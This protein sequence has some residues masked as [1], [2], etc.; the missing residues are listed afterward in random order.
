MY[1]GLCLAGP[2][3]G[4]TR[5]CEDCNL[6]AQPDANP[7]R[8]IPQDVTATDM[9][10]YV[11]YRWVGF[12]FQIGGTPVGNGYWIE[13]HGAA[14]DAEMRHAVLEKLNERYTETPE[15]AWGRIRHKLR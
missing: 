1:S 7:L 14:S 4:Q 3:D 9:A 2:Y 5:E 11:R 6:I 13:A 15:Q 8:E 12:L 10:R